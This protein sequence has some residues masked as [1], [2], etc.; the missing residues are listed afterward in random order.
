MDSNH[1][2]RID[3]NEA[4]GRR[5]YFV[6]MMARRAG[7]EA[8]F[9]ISVDKLRK[10]LAAQSGDSS[11]D[12]S[13]DRSSHG[14][15]DK[16]D[17]K[18]KSAAVEERL[19]PGFGVE[20]ESTAVEVPKFGI[21]IENSSYV[22]TRLAS[23]SSASAG[24]SRSSSAGG[25]DEKIRRWAEGLIRQYDRNR[26][27]KIDRDEMDAVKDEYK[28]GDRNRDGTITRE[29]MTA[30][31]VEYSRQR[32]GGSGSS[33]GTDG[34]GFGPNPWAD[35]NSYRFLSPSERL[36]EGLP[37]WFVAK[38]ANA[39]GQIAMAEYAT[40]WSTPQAAASNVAK[41][42]QFDL[43]RD[44]MITPQECLAAEEA[45]DSATTSITMSGS[46][47]AMPSRT[48]TPKPPEKSKPTKVWSGW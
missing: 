31:L 13:H 25:A 27:G 43:N 3:E 28:K 39:D 16:K 20:A 5:R 44:G 2:G 7:I 14:K 22:A 8:K 41:F 11:R 21:R 10:G 26:N 19:V 1:D 38:D 47:A 33:G 37:D 4:E 24:S 48:Y 15:D 6:E 17:D 34:S 23:S 42:G 45:G 40:D 35:R 46:P 36:P 30:A 12:S 18:G 32:S 29:E 9:P